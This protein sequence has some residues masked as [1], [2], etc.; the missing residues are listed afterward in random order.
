MGVL[1]KKNYLP[2]RGF[3]VIG[4]SSTQHFEFTLEPGGLRFG[5]L[6][7]KEASETSWACSHTHKLGSPVVPFSPFC[8]GVSL[9]KPNSS[10]KGTLI[11]K[12]LLGNLVNRARLCAVWQ[13]EALQP[14]PNEVCTAGAGVRKARG[15]RRAFDTCD[16]SPAEV[17]LC[18][19]APCSLQKVRA[20]QVRQPKP[21]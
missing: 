7:T 10:K 21:E 19:A 17:V 15:L 4:A 13:P 12:G 3:Y 1:W 2:V 11:I 14:E 18:P 16:I 20:V 5:A 9:L 6:R 8:Y